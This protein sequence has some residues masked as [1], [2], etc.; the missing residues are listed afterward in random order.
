MQDNHEIDPQ[1]LHIEALFKQHEI[2]MDMYEPLRDYRK[3]HLDI[4]IHDGDMM[5]KP[6]DIKR[7]DAMSEQMKAQLSVDHLIVRPEDN[8]TC[9]EEVEDR[10]HVLIALFAY[11]PMRSF[12]FHFM[13][14]RYESPEFISFSHETRTTSCPKT[15]EAFAQEAHTQLT[16]AFSRAPQGAAPLY[17]LMN[18]LIM[19]SHE[20]EPHAI[21][22]LTASLPDD[23]NA[24]TLNF[25]SLLTRKLAIKP[26]GVT[27]LYHIMEGI[28]N[29][30]TPDNQHAIFVFTDGQPDGYNKEQLADEKINPFFN[31]LTN[32]RKGKEHACPVSFNSCTNNDAYAEWMKILEKA[33]PYCSECDDFNSKADEIK[34]AQGKGFPF[35]RGIWMLLQI[36]GAISPNDLDLIDEALPFSRFSLESISGTKW[37]I[38]QYNAYWNFFPS[39]DRYA[40]CYDRLANANNDPKFNRSARYFITEEEQ[41]AREAGLYYAVIPCNPNPNNAIQTLNNQVIPAL[42][43]HG[44]NTGSFSSPSVVSIMGNACAFFAQTVFG[45]GTNNVN[46]PTIRSIASECHT[47]YERVM[48]NSQQP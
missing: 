14:R 24:E 46:R 35:T 10:L 1:L 23:A 28:I 34:Q 18:K 30:S 32:K 43:A 12:N 15:P 47:L 36:L 5:L 44:N 25:E 16:E 4:V 33:A 7:M 31:L 38:E 40:D 13:N 42:A 20:N 26:S 48:G 29:K 8:L 22:V 6:S 9:W 19:K 11:I 39:K 37:S 17:N 2:P 3:Y 41:R 27:P 21:I 45:A